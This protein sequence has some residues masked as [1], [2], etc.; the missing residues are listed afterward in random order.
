MIAD[1]DGRYQ[2]GLIGYIGAGV[3]VEDCYA[4]GRVK[5]YW[6]AGGL[7]GYNAGDVV[8]SYS[9][10]EITARTTIGGSIGEDDGKVSDVYWDTKTSG[11]TQGIGL[12]DAGATGEP[13][14]EKTATLRASLPA[15]FSSTIWALSSKINRGFPY[16]IALKSSY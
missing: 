8:T 6:V 1:T 2:G 4:K 16:L 10:G 7:V 9:T 13:S 11:T 14:G 12:L 5:G 15:G 3:T